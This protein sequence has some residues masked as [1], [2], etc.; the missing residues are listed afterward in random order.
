MQ[1]ENKRLVYGNMRLEQENDDLARELVS[2]KIDLRK[3]L[4]VSEDKADTLNK[5]L[6]TANGQLV[7][8]EEERGRL[9]DEVTQ[10]KE[11]LRR[12]VER[13]ER[14]IKRN[15]VI[16][17]DYKQITSHLSERLEKSEQSSKE[18]MERIVEKIKGCE[19]CYSKVLEVR[20][21]S[22]NGHCD[23]QNGDDSSSPEESLEQRVRELEL[24][25]AQTKL[26]LVEAECVNQ[27]L[28]HDLNSAQSELEATSN[29]W[30]KKTI[31][32][33][34]NAAANKRD[35]LASSSSGANSKV[36]MMSREN[37]RDFPN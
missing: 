34:K 19:E 2:S 5:E 33:A 21:G 29:T 9:N 13:T 26:A 3:Q 32:A 6:L 31:R 35:A 14:E 20:D 11:V 15:E 18:K 30:L 1:R 10:L 8:L 7:E 25:L 23:Q 4:D 22:T 27:D 24:E 28:T 36:S 12:E 17:A 37:S 16:I